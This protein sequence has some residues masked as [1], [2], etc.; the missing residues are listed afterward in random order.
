MSD[1]EATILALQTELAGTYSF[2]RELGRGGMGIVFL[3]REVALDRLVA[4]KVLDPERAVRLDQRERFLREARTGARLGHPHIV[5]IYSVGEA[6]GT[7]YFV[8]GLVD[9]ESA[10]ARLHRDGPLPAEEV[11][12]IANE[13]GLALAHAHAM[14]VLHRDVTLDNILLERGSGR[15]MLVDFGIA[16]EVT[17]ASSAALVGTPAYLAPELIQGE[18]PSAQSDLYSLGIATWAMLT[19]RLPF[20]EQEVSQVLIHQLA[21]PIPSLATAAAATP[22]RVRQAVEHCLAKSPGER[23]AN[24]EAWLREL[25]ARDVTPA[26]AP[27]LERWVNR[28]QG[29][30]VFYALGISITAMLSAVLMRDRFSY[31][32]MSSLLTEAVAFL[33]ALLIA[34]IVHANISGR[35]LRGLARSG[36][37]IEDLRLALARDLERRRH[38]APPTRTLLQRLILDVTLLAFGLWIA[39]T[40]FMQSDDMRWWGPGEESAFFALLRWSHLVF[41]SGI[42]LQIINPP[43]RLSA[44]G[45]LARRRMAFWNS[46][47]AADVFQKLSLFL[48]KAR[49]AE[50]TLHRP[51]ELMLDLAIE[52]LWGALPRSERRRLREVPRLADALRKR[53]TEA[54]DVLRRLDG[55]PLAG[56]VEA[57]SLTDRL[58]TQERSAI[59]AL[60]RMRIG[61]L[62][63]TGE[64][65][66]P[67]D[68]SQILADAATLHV[69]LLTELGADRE[70]VA[71]VVSQRRLRTGS[72]PTPTPSPA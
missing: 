24:V 54:R 23:P 11:V 2:E 12:R 67:G 49:A 28:W 25:G 38:A 43:F 14:G 10:G 42:S 3:A 48:P 29:I 68:F 35:M 64:G 45:W 30:K 32:L 55:S 62:E 20:P 16:A 72:S 4:I 41:W 53:A 44:D 7:V 39:V 8:M 5:P 51:T 40:L 13:I 1:T 46:E 57:Q 69:E 65:A 34:L 17:G 56:T 9:G 70:V 27:P 22:R 36:Y 50:H 52:D 21:T 6:A 26:L 19:G 71:R 47:F 60:E 66:M 58:R 31:V 63:L 37:G 33:P 15:A 18:P 59:T 61:L